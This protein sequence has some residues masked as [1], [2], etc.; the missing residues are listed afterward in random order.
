[1]GKRLKISEFVKS[2]ILYFEENCNFLPDE[3]EYFNLRSKGKSNIEISLKM[4]VSER[5]VSNLSK[6]VIKKILKVI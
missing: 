6:A 4:N 1:M 3:S 2:E 5:T